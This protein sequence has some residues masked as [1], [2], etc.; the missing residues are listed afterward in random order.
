MKRKIAILLV[1]FGT[2]LLSSCSLISGYT[3]SRLFSNDQEIANSQM[4]KVLNA[5]QNKDKDALKA[6]FSKNAVD[7]AENFDKNIDE[8]FE[9]YQGN[10]IS[11][12]DR[13]ALGSGETMNYGE[14]QKRLDSTYDV[15]TTEGKYRFAI[16]DYII[17]TANPENVGIYSLYIIKAED[18]DEQMA[19][20]GDEKYTPGINI[21]KYK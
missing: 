2:I 20:R 14:R 9:F 15:E 18:T 13:S 3:S 21:N 17:D 19:Y 4:D 5:I 16:E 12:D 10:V 7:K 11:Y 1:V 6:M 8:L